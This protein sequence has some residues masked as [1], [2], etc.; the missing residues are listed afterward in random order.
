LYVEPYRK[1]SSGETFVPCIINETGIYQTE[2]IK[3]SS[4]AFL[5]RDY[6]LVNMADSLKIRV[7]AAGAS[8]LTCTI[9]IYA[10]DFCPTPLH[11][12]PIET[13]TLSNS[14]SE[15]TKRFALNYFLMQNY[16]FMYVELKSN[17]T[18]ISGS[19]T[20]S[21]NVLDENDAQVETFAAKTHVVTKWYPVNAL[22][23]EIIVKFT[24]ASAAN[25]TRVTIYGVC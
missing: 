22:D 5:S 7:N 25:N 13:V 21:W 19:I 12:Q 8:G 16:K 24:G 1:G 18:A 11:I 9:N 2:Y 3:P 6:Y 14:T 23:G 4:D 10:T 15:Q 17:T 20:K